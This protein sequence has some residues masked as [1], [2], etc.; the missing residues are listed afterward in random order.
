MKIFYHQWLFR[1]P[2]H[3]TPLLPCGTKARLVVKLQLLSPEQGKE[4]IYLPYTKKQW[5]SVKA[6]PAAREAQHHNKAK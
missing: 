6:D 3:F 1:V 5:T 4:T 2:L